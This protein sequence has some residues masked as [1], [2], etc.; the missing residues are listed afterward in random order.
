MRVAVYNQMF[1]LNGKSF[2]SNLFGHWAVH[3]QKNP[4]KVFSRTDLNPTFEIVDKSDADVVG[5]V[6]VLEGQEKQ[7]KNKLE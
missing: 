1:G 3:Y 7:L 2:L 4:E 5:I 6:E